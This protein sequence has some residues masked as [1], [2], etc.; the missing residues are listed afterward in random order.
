MLAPTTGANL[1]AGLGHNA[2]V[3][4]AL[5][6]GGVHWRRRARGVMIAAATA[7]QHRRTAAR[8]VPEGGQA[9]RLA[10]DPKCRTMVR[11]ETPSPSDR[12]RPRSRR[13]RVREC[14]GRRSDTP[15]MSR[16]VVPSNRSAQD[17]AQIRRSAHTSLTSCKPCFDTLSLTPNQRLLQRLSS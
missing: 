6:P 14:A 7:L 12:G 17:L 11:D 2:T 15:R 3:Q 16:P 1:A 4:G 5:C 8:R 13:P 9:I 10:S